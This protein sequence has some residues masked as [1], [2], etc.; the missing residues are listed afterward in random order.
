MDNLLKMAF[1][2]LTPLYGGGFWTAFAQLCVFYY[3]VGAFIH[4]GIPTMFA[5]KNIQA[6]ERKP[7]VVSRDSFYSIGE[8]NLMC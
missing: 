4:W 8:E 3:A 6:Q 5:V 1:A 2:T 7:H